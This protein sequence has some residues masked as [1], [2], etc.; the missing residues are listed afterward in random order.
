MVKKLLLSSSLL[1]LC[2]WAQ[3]QVKASDFGVLDKL[4]GYWLMHAKGINFSETW[5]KVN[6]NCLQAVTYKIEG[7]DSVEMDEMQLLRINDE[8]YYVVLTLKDD[9][10]QP[11]RFKLNTLKPVGFIAENPAADYPQKVFYRFKGNQL[12]VHFEGKKEKTFSEIIMQ[13]NR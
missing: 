5:R 13:Y 10:G 6:D 3:A 9:K 12:D 1:L 11:V 2:I 8:I 4:Q 7:R